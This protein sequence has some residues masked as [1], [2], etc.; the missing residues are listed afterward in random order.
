MILSDDRNTF[1]QSWSLW[2]IWPEISS[3]DCPSSQRAVGKNFHTEH[4]EIGGSHCCL[5]RGL[6]EGK[7]KLICLEEMIKTSQCHWDAA[8]S[9]LQYSKPMCNAA[10]VWEKYVNINL[11][12]MHERSGQATVFHYNPRIMMPWGYRGERAGWLTQPS[13][14]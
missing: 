13:Q 5:L 14:M 3:S 11:A 2:L 10:P 9:R 12:D 1:I 6:L 4:T 7:G 8:R